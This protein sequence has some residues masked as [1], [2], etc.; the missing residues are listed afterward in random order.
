MAQDMI[1]ASEI[2]GQ[3]LSRKMAEWRDENFTK[4]RDVKT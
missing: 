2:V 4:A 3:Q 1:E